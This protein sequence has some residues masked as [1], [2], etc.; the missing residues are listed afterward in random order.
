[1]LA[2]ILLVND[3]GIH[4]PGLR[5]LWEA[6]KDRAH[7]TIVAPATEHSG[8]GSSISIYKPLQLQRVTWMDDT[9]A[10]SL[11]GTPADCVKIALSE[12]FNTP[13][14]LLLSGINPGHN[15]GS[16]IFY[17]GTVG[18]AIEGV[19]N[20]I[21]S[22]ALS[23]DEHR[24]PEYTQAA[25]YVTRIV[26][27][28]LAGHLPQDTILNVNFPHSELKGFRLARQGRSYWREVPEQRTHPSGFPYYWLNGEHAVYPE[29][30]ESD[31]GLLAQGYATAVPVRVREL[32][33]ND[34][35]DEHRETFER[36]MERAPCNQK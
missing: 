8:A 23:I 3:D 34:M 21:P 31:I 14:D 29:H 11:S 36:L 16:N 35:L 2:N 15:A 22:A 6:L 17:S 12:V 19:F 27:F 10:Y 5:Y 33:H 1:M 32:T 13:P 26:D 9:P 30:D 4:A 28:L 24:N 25:S 18:A 7:I 20:G